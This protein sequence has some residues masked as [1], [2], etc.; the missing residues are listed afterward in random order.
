MLKN[1]KVGTRLF[2]LVSILIVISVIIMALGMRGMVTAQ[3]RMKYIYDNNVVPLVD[4]GRVGFLIPTAVTDLYRAL[5]HEPGNTSAEVHNDHPVTEHL[6]HAESALKEAEAL[7]QAYKETS[8]TEAEQRLA[9][10]FDRQYGTFVSEV[11]RPT[12][13]SLRAGDYSRPVIERFVRGY[14]AQGVPLEQT[15]RNLLALQDKVAG[16]EYTK[17]DTAYRSARLL[18]FGVFLFGFA[19]SLV[20]SI[21]IVRSIVRPLAGLQTTMAEIEASGDFTRR[22]SMVSADEVGQTGVSFN[23]LL[24]SLQS[25]FGEILRG[26]GQLNSAANEL[27]STAQQ[28]AQGSEMTSESSSALAASVQE[29]TVSIN[30]VSE[31]ARE[32][33]MVTHH[34]GDLSQKGGEVIHRTVAE[35]QAMAGAV[36]ESSEIITELG[37]QSEH[38]SGIVQVIKDVADQT[39]LLALNAAIEAA[40]AGEQG[41]GFAVVADEVRKLAERTAGATGE[42]SSMI[43]AIQ[44]SAQSAVNSM[45]HAAERVESGAALADQ[46]GQAITDIQ[47]GAAQ[48]QTHVNDITSALAEQSIASQTIAQQVERVA[49]AAEENSA[50]AHSSSQ[51]AINI[52]R[53]AQ[54]M[55]TAM[56]RFQV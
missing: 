35:M 41:R 14:R 17:G 42:I 26:V 11:M 9:G 3:D 49:Q 54:A 30:H 29:M 56:A 4:I 47:Q 7:W 50:A 43:E 2:F 55:H 22:I 19:F 5:Q 24:A 33:L 38:I 37:Q 52:D 1:L 25:A 21:V 23:K 28:A 31:N 45:S 16:E 8:L 44:H 10:D 12:I 20:I 34:T 39:N 6:D 27:A 15:V 18:M 32:T 40:R 13:A 36:R 51:S 53:L 48:V 46:A